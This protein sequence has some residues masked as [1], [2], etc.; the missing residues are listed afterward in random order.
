M[1]GA[2]HLC[3]LVLQCGF[4][5]LPGFSHQ[6]RHVLIVVLLQRV[7]QDAAAGGAAQQANGGLVVR[8]GS[9]LLRIKIPHRNAGLAERGDLRS[10]G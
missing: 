3:A 8:T 9:V 4:H 1:A 2:T 6:L 10:V 7:V 5:L